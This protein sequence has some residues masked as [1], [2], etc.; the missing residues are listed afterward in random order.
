MTSLFILKEVCQGQTGGRWT[1]P[2]VQALEN[3]DT[4]H[5]VPFVGGGFRRSENHVQW[6]GTS[7]IFIK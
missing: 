1:A 7:N 5:S 4:I 2:S 6:L 3:K